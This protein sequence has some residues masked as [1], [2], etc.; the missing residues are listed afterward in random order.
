LFRIALITALPQR[1]TVRLAFRVAEASDVE[2]VVGLRAAVAH[3]LTRQHGHGHW[4]CVAS[5]RSVLRDIRTS[6]VLL[7]FSGGRAVATARLATKRPWAI[8]PKYFSPCRQ[9]L[10]LTDMAV[11]PDLQR[12]GIGRR[13]LEQA[14]LAAANWPAHAIR[15]DAYDGPAG[16]GAFY[17]KCGFAERGRVTYRTTSLVYF[18][19]VL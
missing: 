7:G 11:L 8:D 4:S 3:D 16:A 2:A 18:E 19:L 14:R 13:C 1:S 12:C 6:R 9:P 10:Y 17:A 5:D 15:L